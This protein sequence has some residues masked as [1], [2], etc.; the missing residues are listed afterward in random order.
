[1]MNLRLALAASAMLLS[2][3]AAPRFALE[4]RYGELDVSGDVTL[5]DSGAPVSKNS[6][7][8]MGIDGSESAPG[9]VADLQFGS[10]HLTLST[11]SASH[12]SRLFTAWFHGSSA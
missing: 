7:D 10:P 11:E 5:T 4:P 9:L 6:L 3:C 8:D 12:C 1:M 2:S